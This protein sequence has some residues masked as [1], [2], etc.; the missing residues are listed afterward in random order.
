MKTFGKNL[1]YIAKYGMLTLTA[2]L[3]LIG[4]YRAGREDLLL[5]S[6]KIPHTKDKSKKK[7]AKKCQTQITKNSGQYTGRRIL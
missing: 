5:L 7:G 4:R 2:E 6:P 1:Q 3:G